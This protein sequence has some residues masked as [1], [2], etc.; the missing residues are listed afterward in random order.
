MKCRAIARNGV[1]SFF[2]LQSLLAMSQFEL[3]FELFFFEGDYY[4]KSRRCQENYLTK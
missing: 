3:C 4:Y 2:I 1:A